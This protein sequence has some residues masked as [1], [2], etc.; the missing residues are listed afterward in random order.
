[1][2]DETIPK[3]SDSKDANF[4]FEVI[5]WRDKN[6]HLLSRIIVGQDK[7]YISIKCH[8]CKHVEE[9]EVGSIVD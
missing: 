5:D 7:V 3:A 8:R 1:M 4:N 6:G 9:K 2:E